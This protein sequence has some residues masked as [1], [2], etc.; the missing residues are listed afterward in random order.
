MNQ[1]IPIGAGGIAGLIYFYFMESGVPKGKNVS[2]LAPV[3]TDI[4]AWGF[5]GIITYKGI[6][7]NDSTLSF[8]GSALIGIHLA[9]FAAHKIIKN[10]I[11]EEK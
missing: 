3:S 2:Y 10:R 11:G 9:Q 6:E 7:Y 5:G 8:I 4:L 1:A